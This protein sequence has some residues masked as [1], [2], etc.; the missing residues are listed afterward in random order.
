MASSPYLIYGT[1]TESSVAVAQAKVRARNET[2][3]EYQTVTANDSGQYLLDAANFSTSGYQ[4]GDKVTVYVIYRNYSDTETVTIN[5]AAGAATE[6]D[7]ALTEVTDSELIDYTTVQKVY[8]ELD[9]KTTTDISVTRIVHAIQWAE[10]LID[11]KT[12]TSFKIN[13]V[14]DEVH[15]VHRYNYEVSPDYLDT[16]LRGTPV[17]ADRWVGGIMNRVKVDHTPL[18]AVTSLSKNDA[19]A[20]EADSWTALTEQTGSSGDFVVENKDAGIIDFLSDYPRL[21]KRGWKVS[22]TWGY[23]PD[24]SDRE[25]IATMRVVDR[26]A[27]LLA[28][29][30]IITTKSSGSMF[31]STMDV[32][33]GSIQIRSGA[34]STRQYLSAVSIEITEL[35]QALGTLGFEII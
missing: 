34:I 21:G 16:N 13:T 35:W 6:Q 24:S 29:R 32:R 9:G 3:N 26:L 19:A 8:D 5:T 25:I 15:T 2:T 22:Y 28:V 7:L 27:I 31:D 14:S 30:N 23:D 20:S 18:I 33:I 17:R 4:N 1:V 12:E 11:L 10:G